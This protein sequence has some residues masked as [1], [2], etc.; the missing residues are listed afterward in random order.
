MARPYICPD[1]IITMTYIR[2]SAMNHYPV[3]TNM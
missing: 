1:T 3:K 2:V